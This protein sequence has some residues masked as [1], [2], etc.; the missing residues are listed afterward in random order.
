MTLQFKFDKPTYRAVSLDPGIF[1]EFL[2]CSK[3][4]VWSLVLN[5]HGRRIVFS[6][7]VKVVGK[8][9]GPVEYH[10]TIEALP[11]IDRKIPTWRAS[12][13]AE[14]REAARMALDAM[15]IMVTPGRPLAG[16]IPKISARHSEFLSGVL[17]R[18]HI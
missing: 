13:L 15:S 11:T 7:R 5:W 18:G 2:G 14:R 8:P 3:E 16:E 1:V 9:P 12:S 6:A 4:D 17:E 10:W